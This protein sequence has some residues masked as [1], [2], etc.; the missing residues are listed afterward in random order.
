MH[1]TIQKNHQ[2]VRMFLRSIILHF[3]FGAGREPSVCNLLSHQVTRQ[4][5][6]K[7]KPR[8]CNFLSEHCKVGSKLQPTVFFVCWSFF[9]FWFDVLFYALICWETQGVRLHF[10]CENTSLSQKQ[11]SPLL[12]L[13]HGKA[14][15]KPT[16]GNEPALPQL[17]S[18]RDPVGQLTQGADRLRQFCPLEQWGWS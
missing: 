10:R 5:L 9:L 2:N 7:C 13:F 8:F 15:N 18:N 12:K 11:G 3:L 17:K 6:W 1:A 4:T 14:V 16:M